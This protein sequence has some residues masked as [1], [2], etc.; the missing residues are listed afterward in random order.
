M[1]IS[2]CWPVLLTWAVML[3]H[4]KL[5]QL[6][7]FFLTC[8]FQWMVISCHLKVEIQSSHYA[9]I[10]L[11]QNMNSKVSQKKTFMDPI[12]NTVLSEKIIN[13]AKQIKQM[14]TNFCSH[15]KVSILID[16][17]TAYAFSMTKYRNSFTQWLYA[18]NHLTWST[19]DYQ[20]YV[21]IQVKKVI[22][23]FSRANL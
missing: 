1:G 9:M 6:F 4:F 15:F 12:H 10:P 17:N 23:I 8:K 5:Q 20:I 3:L 13:L 21:I 11:S 19:R 16:I 18:L 2:P 22:Y 14:L 7:P